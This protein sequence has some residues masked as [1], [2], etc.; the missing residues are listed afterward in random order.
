MMVRNLKSLARHQ[1]DHSE[2]A[3]ISDA[4]EMFR[5]VVAAG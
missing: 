2:I 1:P 3:M 4:N 5:V